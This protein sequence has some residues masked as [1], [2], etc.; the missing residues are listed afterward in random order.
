MYLLIFP[1]SLYYPYIL[2]LF[3]FMKKRFWLWAFYDFANS[4][5]FMMVS[6]YFSLWFVGDLRGPDYWIS[7]VVAFTTIVLIFTLPALGKWSDRLQRRMPF[8]RA[9]TLL[10]S[11]TLFL[12]G[13]VGMEVETPTTITLITVITLYALFQY[14]Y[15]ASIGFY[16]AFMRDI[17]SERSVEKAA[18]IGLALGQLGNILA[19]LIALPLVTYF[20][21]PST[22]VAGGV[23]FVVFSLPTLLFLKDE[24]QERKV[25]HAVAKKSFIDS[26]E[27]F[28]RLKY[29]PNVFRYL[30]AY[31]FFADALLTM[32]LFL[33]LYLREVGGFSDSVISGAL[34]LGIV[35]A[36]L[37]G[38]GSARFA[39]RC[40]GSK[41]AISSLIVIWT[42]FLLALA[43]S[44]STA[45]LIVVTILNGAAFGLLFSLSRAFYSEITP[46]HHQ[47]EF[48]GLYV[49]FERASSIIGPLLWSGT[50]LL[51][52]S[53]GIDRYRFAMASLAG[54]VAISYF[55][56]KKVAGK[57]PSFS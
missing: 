29:E 11:A 26:L 54:M 52:S 50:L 17:S 18:G 3:S 32:Q 8:L 39:Q 38:I 28:R 53:Y 51:F 41:R 47:G 10:A 24:V 35:A 22:F 45:L 4:L 46:V 14:I 49:L 34:V 19:I 13:I 44:Q 48:F 5:A 7:T 42:L 16:A 15:Q 20:D 25:E 56:L 40:G 6:F 1:S 31:Y 12:L 43:L 57:S 21:R 55:I 23:L 37:G 36:I 30:I 27:S 33:T 9:T 2:F